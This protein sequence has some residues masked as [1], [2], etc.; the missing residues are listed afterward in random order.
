[1]VVVVTPPP[2]GAPLMYLTDGGRSEG[3]F[4]SEV[5]AKKDFLGL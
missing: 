5:L 1:M 2:P 4:G 3:I